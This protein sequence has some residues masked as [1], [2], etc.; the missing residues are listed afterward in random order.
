[1][2]HYDIIIVGSGAGGATL[3]YQ[4]ADSGKQ[5]LVIER[6]DFI[7]IEKENWDSEEVFVKNRYTTSETLQCRWKHKVIRCG[8]V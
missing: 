1:L 3:A 7:P 6:G 5:I 8:L 2:K 4:L